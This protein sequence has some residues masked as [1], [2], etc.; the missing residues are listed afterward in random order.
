[1][2]IYRAS[3]RFHLPNPRVAGADNE[4]VE[5]FS[6]LGGRLTVTAAQTRLAELLVGQTYRVEI[7]DVLAGK[8]EFLLGNQYLLAAT[9]F[10]FSRGDVVNLRLIERSAQLLVFQLA[11]PA[12]GHGEEPA[13]LLTLLRAA[14]LPDT[15]ANRAALGLL[16]SNGISVNAR[17]VADIS[18]LLG[19]LPQSVV[20]AFLP[21]YGE[22]VARGLHLAPDL[23]EQLARLS[24]GPPELA[25][26]LAVA[27]QRTKQRGGR[28]SLDDAIEAALTS[29]ARE[30]DLP[31]ARLLKDKLRLLYGSPEK[32]LGDALLA[33]GDEPDTEQQEVE[34]GDLANLAYG[35][36]VV[37]ELVAA[38]NVLQALRLD[39]SL[40][41]A[42]LELAL[43]MMLDGE[44]TEVQLSINL[45]AE[46][47]YQKDYAVRLRVANAIQGRVEI[48]LRTR[49]PGLYVDVLAAEPATVLAYEGLADGL[50]GEI[51]AQTPFIVRR[52][53]VGAASL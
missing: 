51:E 11:L 22:L 9:N 38:L 44:A 12:A 24:G 17:T 35:E 15:A 13:G 42:A 26:L 46:Q 33:L 7:T 34:L 40:H 30:E 21:L 49:G 29:V 3:A 5:M 37:A 4:V 14:G 53:E 47:Y 1:M 2:H 36:P 41:P 19:A 28:R 32:A 43:P 23:L 18:Q 39:A 45:L 25:G 16:L 8:V 6:P 50:K 48:Q 52:I 27:L 10:R 20:T 31:T